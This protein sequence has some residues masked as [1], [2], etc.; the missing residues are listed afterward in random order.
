[1]SSPPA[2]EAGR[3]DGSPAPPSFE[4]LNLEPYVGPKSH[5]ASRAFAEMQEQTIKRRRA[6]KMGVV[7]ALVVVGGGLAWAALRVFGP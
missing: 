7:L 5:H 1:M 6:K 2:P 4:R 3:P